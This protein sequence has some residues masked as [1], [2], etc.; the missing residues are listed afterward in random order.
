MTLAKKQQLHE[1]ALFA[2][3]RAALEEITVWKTLTFG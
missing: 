2:A 1:A 3:G